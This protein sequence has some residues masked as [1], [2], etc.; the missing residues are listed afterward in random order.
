MSYIWNEFNIKTFRAETIVFRD[1]EYCPE[2]ST[3]DN[4]PINTKYDLPVHIIYVGEIYGDKKLDI[5]VG[6]ENQEVILSVNLKIKKPAFLNI[7]IKNAG[8][9]SKISGTVLLDNESELSYNCQARH[10][11]ENTAILIKNKVLAGKNSYS[12]LSGMAIIDKDCGGCES[13]IAFVAMTDVG[14]KIDFMPG[15]RIKSEPVRAD[16]S[17]SIYK[18]TDAQVFFL[19]GAGLSGAEVDT[20]LKEAFLSE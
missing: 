14:A 15:Q 13:D 1:G 4:T 18:P 17:A 10:F 2:L 7:F 5:S 9:N 12:K 6:A 16:H 19:R 8:K 3:L 20:A 11:Y